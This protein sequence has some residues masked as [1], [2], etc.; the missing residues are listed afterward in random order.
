MT[1]DGAPLL[2]PIGSR[3]WVL[4]APLVYHTTRGAIEVPAGFIT[5]LASIPRVF[6]PLVPVNGRHRAAAILHDFL[7]VTQPGTRAEADALFL[8]AMHVSGVRWSQRKVM[9]AAVRLGG[10]LAWAAN[11][12]ALRADPVAHYRANGL[13]HT[14]AMGA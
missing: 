7:Y 4:M 14:S 2:Q 10:G 13:V 9:H 6:W 3:D 11:L 1:F 12:R 5:D 8:E